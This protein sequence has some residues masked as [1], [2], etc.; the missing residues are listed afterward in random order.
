MAPISKIILFLTAVVFFFGQLLRIDLK[1]FSF[2][3][4]DIFIFLLFLINIF[5]KFKTK[6]W[7]I[8]NKF[9]LYFLI[10]AWISFLINFLIHPIY[11]LTP[12]FYLFRLTFLF[13]FFIFPI[14]PK[15]L[16]DKF[17][18]VFNL[19][20]FANVIFGLIQY[21]FWPDFTYFDS[22]DWDPH[23]F[24]LVSTFFDPTFT[25]LIFLL[26]LIKIFL[27]QK[28]PFRKTLLFTTYLALALTYSRSSL[29]AF[30]V[31]FS[32]ISLKTKKT[33][34]FFIALIIFLLT[35]ISL[36]RQAGEGTK[37][38][39]T[40]SIKAKIENYKEGLNIFTKSPIIG[41]GYNNLSFVRNI[42]NKNSHA[43][44]GFDSSL[45]TIITTTGIIGFI[46]FILGIKNEFIQSNLTKKTFWIAIL[47]HSLFANSLLYPWILIFFIF[48]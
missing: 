38:E 22:L 9:F 5:D 20:I 4:I 42:S 31:S 33:K 14:N 34:I 41:H 10:F 16:S 6:N 19:V 27:D 25:G 47:F 39:R 29:I 44:F 8:K 28:I 45:L 12:I 17:H 11:S 2:P 46:L 30:L 32:F 13:S 7:Q 1:N 23:L 37:L 35:I 40:S 26:F 43:N 21:F 48:T 15:I 18:K 36:P 3:L 24:R